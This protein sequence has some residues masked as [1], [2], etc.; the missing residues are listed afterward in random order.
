MF[1]LDRDGR[2]SKKQK[3]RENLKR[4]I[5]QGRDAEENFRHSQIAQGN[6]CRKIHEGG[7]FLVQKR[8]WQRRNIGKPK[9]YEIKTGK[10]PLSEAQKRK[11]ARIGKDYK[12]ERY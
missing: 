10:S 11:K 1:N 2:T 4:N 6:D 5:R 12:V 3:L 7:D 9:T 8:D